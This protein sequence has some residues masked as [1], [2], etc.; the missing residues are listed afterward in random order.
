M[1]EAGFTLLKLVFDKTTVKANGLQHCGSDQKG[2]TD[3]GWYGKGKAQADK[4][5]KSGMG[6]F[7]LHCV[8]KGQI[9]S[10]RLERIKAVKLSVVLLQERIEEVEAV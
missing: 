10:S 6:E 1:N 2:K 4:W 9:A 3:Q 7:E 8:T 5:I